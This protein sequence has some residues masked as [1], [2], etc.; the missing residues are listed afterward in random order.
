MRTL[1]IL[2]VCYWL[3][4]IFSSI[5]AQAQA[6]TTK[7][8]STK[9]PSKSLFNAD[10]VVSLTLV[11]DLSSLLKNRSSQT[12][13]SYK[14]AFS[15]VD[16][17]RNSLELP[18]KVMVRGNFRRDAKNC[19]FPPLLLDFPKTKT[20]NTPFARHAKLKLVTHCQT[21]EY[22]VREYLV[23]KLYNLLT[24]FSFRARLAK[25]TYQDSTGKRDTETKYGFLLEDENSVARRNKATPYPSANKLNMAR[26]DTVQMAT[27]AVFE[28][29]I[30]NTD[31]S[32]PFRHNIRLLSNPKRRAPMPVP[33]DFDHSGIVEAPYALPAEQL[34]IQSVRQRLYRGYGYPQPVF[35]RVFKKFRKHK[36]AIYAL[37]QNQTALPPAYMKRTL[38]Y[39]DEF[40]EVIDSP[41]LVKRL[42]MDQGHQNA[43]GGVVIKGLN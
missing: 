3:G 12:P 16:G 15:Y 33:Y 11:A 20:V 5:Q 32:V 2:A 38:K 39:L 42:F 9:V 21:E 29:L 31:W 7:K 19:R 18:V 22:V 27:V 24:D 8:V 36:T 40:Y 37:Y 30:G 14:A 43:T 13:V 34:E 26:A 4:L 41:R 1:L 23:Y 6:P 10:E 28:Y 35:D 17:T 25:V